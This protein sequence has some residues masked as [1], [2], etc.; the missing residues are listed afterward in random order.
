MKGAFL[1]RMLRP[2]AFECAPQNLTVVE[3]LCSSE[4]VRANLFCAAITTSVVREA[5]SASKR[6]SS[7]RPTASSASESASPRPRPKPSGANEET[8]SA[9]L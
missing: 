9:N 6:R 3:S 1:P 7:A 4:R 8:A 2:L 5:R